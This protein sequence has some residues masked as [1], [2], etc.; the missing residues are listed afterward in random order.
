MTDVKLTEA[1][2]R[3]LMWIRDREPVSMFP[4]GEGPQMWFVRRLVKLGLVEAAGSEAGQW[5]F[6]RFVV[7]PTG[8]AALDREG[9]R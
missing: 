4:V 3:H 5:G 6:T 9:E 2:R 8:R 7:S 1:Q